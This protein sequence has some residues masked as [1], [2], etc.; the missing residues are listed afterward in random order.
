[1]DH[2]ISSTINLPRNAD[3]LY[4][5]TDFA[6]TL[7]EYLPRLRGVTCY[8]DGARGGQPL[9]V[10]PYDVAVEHEGVVFEEAED[11]CVGGVCGA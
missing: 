1:V 7:Y 11:K 10:V 6:A 9:T 2:A 8:P 5:P 4:D 3:A